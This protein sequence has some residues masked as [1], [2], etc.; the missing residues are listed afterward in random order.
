MPTSAKWMNLFGIL[1][2][3][4]GACNLGLAAKEPGAAAGSCSF[5]CGGCGGGEEP[6]D[7]I[8]AGGGL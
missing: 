3:E 5:S 4:N 1:I 8:D 6:C 7:R 2:S